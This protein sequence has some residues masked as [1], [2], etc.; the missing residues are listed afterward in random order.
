MG[1]QKHWGQYQKKEPR[2][3]SKAENIIGFI[4]I[5]IFMLIVGIGMSGGKSSSS[6]KASAPLISVE[7]Q[8]AERTAK[9]TS[10]VRA[11]VSFLDT[12]ESFFKTTK[13]ST[14]DMEKIR[15]TLVLIE[16]LAD[17]LNTARQNKPDLSPSD[18]K[19]L[20]GIETRLSSF[21]QRVLPGLRLA[22]KKQSGKLLWE[23]D[24]DVFV[25]GAGNTTITFVG[26]LF[27]SNANIKTAQ[28]KL[29]DVIERLRFKRTQFKW[30]EDADK[31]TYYKIPSPPDGKLAP[32]K[33]GAF[34][35]M[36]SGYK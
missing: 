23:H 31:Y 12:E 24:V 2:K 13:A 17:S 16:S 6:P 19:Y 26:T 11:Y 15:K 32:F 20:K 7:D 29:D 8:K 22:F 18:I 3:P 1:K 21:Q 36:A 14:V 9:Y 10:Q 4:L 25:S 30:Y 5:A 34:Q 27:A 28:T 33:F 35:E